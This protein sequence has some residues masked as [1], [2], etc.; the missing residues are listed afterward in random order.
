MTEHSKHVVLMRR[1]GQSYRHCHGRER[2]Q[3]IDLEL[4]ERQHRELAVVYRSLGAQVHE[5]EPLESH[6]DSVFVEDAVI[7]VDGVALLCRPALIS[8]RG[9]AKALAPWLPKH[10]RVERFKHP[11]L[12]DGGDCID[13]G[14]H[15]FVGRSRRTN[16]AAHAQLAQLTP[17]RVVIPVPVEHDTL[18]LKSVASY[19]GRQQFLIAPGAVDPGLFSEYQI[20]QAPAGE[21]QGVNCVAVDGTIVVPT[22]HSETNHLLADHDFTVVNVDISEFIKGDGSLTCLSVFVA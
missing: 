22:G 16:A 4:A 10:K 18:H 20:L 14:R 11:A 3:P 6:P 15:L 21:A 2:S 7:V 17:S 8:R 1:P 9:E 19:L 13:T 5:L 12:I